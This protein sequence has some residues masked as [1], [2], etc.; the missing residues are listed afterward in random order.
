[1]KWEGVI[2]A[3]TTP[4]RDDS[5][6]DE[7]FVLRHVD[8]FMKAGCTGVVA[9]G[10]LGEGGCLSGQEKTALLR[11]CH[12]G[13][14]GRG[15]LVAGIAAL[16][17]ADAVALA[18]EAER[19]G[20][21]GLMVLPPYVYQGDWRE[22]KAHFRAV[23]SATSLSC[24]LYNNPIAYGTDVLPEQLEE[25]CREL[26]NLLAVKESSADVRRV[27]TLR[28]RL[29]DRLSLLVGVDDLIVEGIA[30]G[31]VGWIALIAGVVGICLVPGLW[32]SAVM[33]RTGVGPAAR[34]AT[35]IGATLTWYALVGPVVHLFAEGA[36]VTAGG[37]VGV[38]AA[39]TAAVCL[40]IVFGLVHRPA[41]PRLRFPMA[42][43]VGGL[44]AQAVIWLS[45]AFS[46]DGMN[47]EQIRRLDW[48][49]VLSCG[50]L[51]AIGAHTR[52]DLPVIRT[53]RHIR[54][55]LIS[56]A[57]V[58]VTAAALFAFGTRWSPAQRMPSAIGIEEVAAPPGS[59]VAFALT[60]IGPD[61]QKMIEHSA[62]SAW[63]DSGQPVP[64][65]TSVVSGATA[66]SAT[67][68]V[69]VDPV[70]RPQLCDRSVGGSVQGWPIKLTVR[71]QTSGVL[72]QAVLPAAWCA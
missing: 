4:F 42:G 11:T 9:L 47:Y 19:C 52:P 25:L 2:P 65:S 55:V 13:L 21:S 33:M 70:S 23:I 45:I 29:G 72:V 22:T 7:A 58:A 16:S 37:I 12:E 60:A 36:R 41:N 43:L 44:C 59:D 3:M 15:P 24:M 66:D 35:R 40:G 68:L 26:P 50:L 6:I 8:A 38:T 57:V 30:A 17:T 34:L 18:R 32:L 1:M 63:D 28:A 54:A 56:L 61:G 46:T 14:G 39:A 64:V 10:S 53:A 27:T 51:T 31:A 67:L 71:D 69:V 5:S 49:I 48:L 62:F 20:C